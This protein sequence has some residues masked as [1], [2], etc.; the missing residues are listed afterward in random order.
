[1]MNQAALSFWRDFRRKEV[2]CLLCCPNHSDRGGV[3]EAS[4]GR[5]HAFHPTNVFYCS[6]PCGSMAVEEEEAVEAFLGYMRKEE[7]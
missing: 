6:T 4:I 2:R 1:M 7:R 5:T 3:A